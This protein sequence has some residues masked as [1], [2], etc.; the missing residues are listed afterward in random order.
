MTSAMC[1]VPGA[2]LSYVGSPPLI[3]MLLAEDPSEQDSH[4]WWAIFVGVNS[5]TVC[6]VDELVLRAKWSV[7]YVPGQPS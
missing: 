1:M 5:S 3:V 6:L 7:V 2:V 4:R